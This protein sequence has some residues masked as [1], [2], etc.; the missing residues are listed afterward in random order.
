MRAVHVPPT[1]ITVGADVAGDGA[2]HGVCALPPRRG[3]EIRSGR[4]HE[5]L[6]PIAR[7]DDTRIVAVSG[8]SEATR[9]TRLQ[10]PVLASWA[11][12][13]RPNPVS[14]VGLL[15]RRR[16]RLDLLT[17]VPNGFDEVELDVT[18]GGRRVE[19]WLPGANV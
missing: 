7:I 6:D 5:A 9:T 19:V 3:D 10:A 15:R 11:K 4:G 14:D 16:P 18:R 13:R 1:A 2:H 12:A 17:L 8:D